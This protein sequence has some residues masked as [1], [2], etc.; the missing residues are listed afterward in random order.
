[1]CELG[2]RHANYDD[3]K[4]IRAGRFG[5]ETVCHISI[6]ATDRKDHRQ[7]TAPTYMECMSLS[8]A[9]RPTPLRCCQTATDSHCAPSVCVMPRI[10]VLPPPGASHSESTSRSCPWR[11]ISSG[12]SAMIITVAHGNHSDCMR[13]RV[14]KLHVYERQAPADICK[15]HWWGRDASTEARSWLQDSTLHDART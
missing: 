13:R 8:A 7:W 4:Q 10:T 2:G 14:V 9:L 12:R 1:M 15:N 6:L 5:D 11:H 3:A